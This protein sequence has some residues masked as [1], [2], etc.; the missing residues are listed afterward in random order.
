LKPLTSDNNIVFY[1]GVCGLCDHTVQFLLKLDSR[2][3][4]V[5]SPLQGETAKRL[6]DSQELVNLQSIIFYRDQKKFYRSRAVLE[7]LNSIGGIWHCFK[8]L[9]LIPSF[10]LDFFYNLIARYRYQIFGHYDQCRVPSAAE[11]ARFLP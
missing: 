3:E 2:K 6:L 10:I 7:I 11:K 5:F 8:I 9:K 1:D 4:L